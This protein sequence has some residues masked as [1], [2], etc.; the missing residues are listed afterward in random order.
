[1]TGMMNDLE[2]QEQALNNNRDFLIKYLDPDDISD[3]LIQEG[4]L[5]KNAA[6]R[7]QLHLTS[8]MEKNQTIVDQLTIGG[9]GT[10]Q[11]FCDIL[12]SNKRLTFIAEK[13]E[14]GKSFASMLY[15]LFFIYLLPSTLV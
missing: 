6:Q 11:K 14:N 1:M 15:T 3:Q 9:P 12:K 8:R 2:K 7:A 4:M 13:L 10:L 5:G